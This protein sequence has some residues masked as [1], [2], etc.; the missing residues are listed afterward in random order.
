[1]DDDKKKNQRWTRLFVP[2]PTF[3]WYVRG[4]LAGVA[5][6]C[7]VF[8]WILWNFHGSHV[9]GISAGAADP[10]VRELVVESSR[11][12]LTATAVVALGCLLF[13]VVMSMYLLHRIS[14]PIYRLRNHIDSIAR[15]G[16]VHEL[17]FRKDDQLLDL[18]RSFNQMMRRLGKL[19]RI[20]A[21][22]AAADEA[23]SAPVGATSTPS[24][25]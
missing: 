18:A 11:H 9:E 2:D 22:Q 14:G 3:G 7:V 6:G 23:S 25:A 15:G 24:S 21:P 12:L 19:E 1:M 17:T 5:M 13:V 20:G 8:G 10:A 16:P 4:M